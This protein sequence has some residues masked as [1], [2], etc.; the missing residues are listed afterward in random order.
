MSG[1]VSALIMYLN[2]I[3]FIFYSYSLLLFCFSEL[4]LY[5]TK[6]YPNKNL[7]G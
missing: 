4:K 2:L 6:K 1:F 5:R 3:G 7:Q